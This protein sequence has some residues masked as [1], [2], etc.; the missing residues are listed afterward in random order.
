MYGGY[1]EWDTI[2]NIATGIFH[3]LSKNIN[4]SF[5]GIQKE[6]GPSLAIEQ[7]SQKVVGYC[8]KFVCDVT[9]RTLILDEE[10]ERELEQEVQ[11]EREP[12]RPRRAEAAKPSI[13]ANVTRFLEIGP[14]AQ[15]C[16]RLAHLPAA[17]CN[18]ILEKYLQVQAWG[19]DI[20]VSKDFIQ[21]VENQAISSN[22]DDY[23]KAPHWIISHTDKEKSKTTLLIISAYEAN[24]TIPTFRKGKRMCVLHMFAARRFPDQRNLFSIERLL[25][26]SRRYPR[27]CTAAASTG[28]NSLLG[29]S[30]LDQPRNLLTRAANEQNNEIA[31]GN[32]IDWLYSELVLFAGSLYF[33][34]K[35]EQDEYARFMGIIP[36]K[37][38]EEEQ[39][40]FDEGKAEGSA[41]F[42]KRDV[43]EELDPTWNEHCKFQQNPTNLA[44]N[45]IKIRH[46]GCWQ[47]KSHIGQILLKSMKT[48]E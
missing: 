33:E 41:A 24:E 21:T 34:N 47:K 12:D 11:Q 20:Y 25:V 42:L 19:K 44:L 6:N 31:F 32:N 8:R 3:K 30:R 14:T 26:T 16:T 18:T 5:S 40:I 17:F 13:D 35:T 36:H 46:D 4:Q 37:R 23:L 9:R 15:V 10:Q 45:I 29:I 38:T 48:F 22:V 27:A 28:R 1:T 43:R 2:P 7:M 39:R